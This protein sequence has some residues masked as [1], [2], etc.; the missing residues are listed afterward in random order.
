M[1]NNS[2]SAIGNYRIIHFDEPFL[3]VTEITGYTDEVIGDNPPLVTVFKEF[4]WSTDGNGWSMW[5]PLTLENLQAIPLPEVGDQSCCDPTKFFLELRYSL[6]SISDESV[7]PPIPP[8]ADNTVVTPSVKILCF[9]LLYTTPFDSDTIPKPI[10]LTCSDE[11][12]ATQFLLKN[13][14]PPP[15]NGIG[16]DPHAPYQPYAIIN[17]GTGM[18][19][20]ISSDITNKFGFPVNYYRVEPQQRSKDVILKE[21]TI[22]NVAETGKIKVIVPNN[23]F[24]DNKFNFN[25]HGVDFEAPFEIQITI[26]HWESIF[27]VGTHPRKRDIIDFTLLDRLY[28]I[29]GVYPFRNFMQQ[30]LYFRAYLIKYQPKTNTLF[31]DPIIEKEIENKI[32]TTEKLFGKETAETER[33]LTNPDQFHT[34]TFSDDSTRESINTKLSIASYDLMNDWTM[35]SENYYSLDSV[36]KSDSV[37]QDLAIGYRLPISFIKTSSRALSAWFS[38]PL[39]NEGTFTERNI[40]SAVQVPGNLLELTT[41][42]SHD[43]KVGDTIMMITNNSERSREGFFEVVSVAGSPTNVLRI[44]DKDPGRAITSI[45]SWKIKK[46]NIRNVIYGLYN[47]QGTKVDLYYNKIGTESRSEVRMT[48]N[49]KVFKTTIPKNTIESDNLNKWY[50]LVINFSN[51]YKQLGFYV[52]KMIADPTNLQ[53]QTSNLSLVHKDVKT[54]EPEIFA[55]ENKY[56][57]VG[58]PLYLTNI[59]IFDEMIPEDD[60]V[61]VLNHN[62]VQDAQRALLIDNAKL[63]LRLPRIARQR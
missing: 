34:I 36:W 8:L 48:L 42:N 46:S 26:D 11:Y 43:H 49:D 6:I 1:S 15:S 39:I 51:K 17:K 12:T 35:I 40:L 18:Y 41:V 23:E 32:I 19:R 29:Q 27:G 44:E 31:E 38:I 3:N 20:T 28:E 7:T 9:E 4:R 2:L 59:R 60:Q 52:W 10:H 62:L 14:F 57:L 16:V 54:L 13:Q 53:P 47:N 55:L 5:M 33:K 63:S 22:H 56:S 25:M 50:G 45:S 61:V 21:N 58:S 37:N 24:P 30:I